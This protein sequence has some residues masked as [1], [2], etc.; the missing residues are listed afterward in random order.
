MPEIGQLGTYLIGCMGIAR[1]KKQKISQ[2]VVYS[3]K[4]I[5]LIPIYTQSYFYTIRKYLWITSLILTLNKLAYR[6]AST[7]KNHTIF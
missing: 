3:K 1:I 6:I 4:C 7:Q 2:N 5:S